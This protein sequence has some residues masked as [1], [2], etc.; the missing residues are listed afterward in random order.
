MSVKVFFSEIKMRAT[1]FKILCTGIKPCSSR[2]PLRMK[3]VQVHFNSLDCVS[4]IP[5]KMQYIQRD[6]CSSK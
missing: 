5:V 6:Q 4:C 2:H 3:W 1:Y